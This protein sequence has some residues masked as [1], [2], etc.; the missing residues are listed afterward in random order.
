MTMLGIFG[1]LLPV[2]LFVGFRM[3]TGGRPTAGGDG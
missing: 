3:F 1:F 2:H